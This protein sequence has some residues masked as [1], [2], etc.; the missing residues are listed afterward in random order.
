MKIE[1][2]IEKKHLIFFGMFIILI[3]SIFVLADYDVFGHL[4]DEIGPGTMTGPISINQGWTYP[5]LPSAFYAY[6]NTGDA[7][8]GK[9]TVLGK[10][11]IYGLASNGAYSG[12]FE[13]GDVGI[14]DNKLL[15]KN[16]VIPERS[17]VSIGIEGGSLVFEDTM[18]GSKTLSE[19]AAGGGTSTFLGLTDSPAT[20]SGNSGKFVAVKSTED[21]LEFVSSSPGSYLPGSGIDIITNV[22]SI[23]DA[24]STPRYQANHNSVYYDTWEYIF[25]PIQHWGA[26]EVLLLSIC[27]WTQDAYGLY[28]VSAHSLTSVS[29]HEIGQENLQVDYDS[30]NIRFKQTATPGSS[31]DFRISLM[32]LFYFD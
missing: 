16:D 6:S 20:Y 29:I 27:S 13:G 17:T 4:A 28:L 26:N 18:V 2:N 19:L 7:I 14:Y 25:N 5:T 30:P 8:T 31:T 12:W 3:S 21:S 22:I 10:S 23:E 11:A 24:Y 1:I 32:R 15:F 9:S